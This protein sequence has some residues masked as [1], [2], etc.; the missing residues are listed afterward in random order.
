MPVTEW[1]ELAIGVKAAHIRKYYYMAYKI[2]QNYIILTD[3]KIAMN[4]WVGG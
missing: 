1:P 3:K 4:E 2:Q